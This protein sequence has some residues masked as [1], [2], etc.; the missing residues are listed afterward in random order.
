MSINS[1]LNY[2]GLIKTASP[3]PPV[4]ILSTEDELRWKMG[5]Q[6]FFFEAEFRNGHLAIENL[7]VN[8]GGGAREVAGI[9]MKYDPIEEPILE[10]LVKAGKYDEAEN[11]AISYIIKDT[12]AAA[13]W[14]YAPAIE[15]YFR[16]IIFNRGTRGCIL[17]A[18]R[19]LNISQDGQWGAISD[20][21][22]KLAE[23]DLNDF[24]NRLHQA[25]IDYE[26]EVVGTRANFDTGLM[27]RFQKACDFAKTFI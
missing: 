1:I 2:F 13:H 5:K 8:D 4:P 11:S 17:I 22:E 23:E 25:R 20:K 15:S 27:N 10:A 12:D 21:T 14:C 3:L 16:D 7:P 9:N 26:H 18:Q 19:A 6:I 24:L